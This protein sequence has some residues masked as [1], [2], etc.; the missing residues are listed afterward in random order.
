MLWLQ[1]YVAQGLIVAVNL[2]EMSFGDLEFIGS[3][4][5]VLLQP[6]ERL[7]ELSMPSRSFASVDARHDVKLCEMRCVGGNVFDRLTVHVLFLLREE[8]F[9]PDTC[10][11]GVAPRVDELALAMPSCVQLLIKLGATTP[12]SQNPCK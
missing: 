9:S 6:S 10:T 4:A 12:S 1:S 11:A 2:A 8:T 3:G 5:S 7:H